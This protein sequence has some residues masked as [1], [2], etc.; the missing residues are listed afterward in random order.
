MN[1]VA[2]VYSKNDHVSRVWMEYDGVDIDLQKSDHVDLKKLNAKY[3]TF[4]DAE[5][6]SELFDSVENMARVFVELDS[7]EIKELFNM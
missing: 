4:Y 3:W 7:G 2:H 6:T 5:V 1:I